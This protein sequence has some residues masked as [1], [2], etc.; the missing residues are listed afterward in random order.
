MEETA[1]VVAVT[2][3]A[4][5]VAPSF[6][7]WEDHDNNNNNNSNSNSNS[8]NNNNNSS[9]SSHNND[10]GF[11]TWDD[12]TTTPAAVVVANHDLEDN[13]N[14]DKQS[15]AGKT[16]PILP[17]DEDEEDDENDDEDIGFST[18]EHENHHNNHNNRNDN[19]NNDDEPFFP[20]VT[21][22]EESTSHHDFLFGNN[23]NNNN[24]SAHWM[25]PEGEDFL[26]PSSSSQGGAKPQQQ[27]QQALAATSFHSNGDNE[28]DEDLFAAASSP[29][30]GTK[31]KTRP[32]LQ[33]TKNH[34]DEAEAPIM[35]EFVFPNDDDND[36]QDDDE[37]VMVLDSEQAQRP[38]A[39]LQLQQQQQFSSDPVEDDEDDEDHAVPTQEEMEAGDG[40]AAFVDDENDNDDK[41]QEEEE[42]APPSQQPPANDEDDSLDS[43]SERGGEPPQPVHNSSSSSSKSRTD[44]KTT[45]KK[46][47]TSVDQS[48]AKAAA[49]TANTNDHSSSRRGKSR[50]SSRDDDDDDDEKQARSSGKTRSSS[51]SS[52]T[53]KSSRHGYSRDS[54]RKLA[55]KAASLSSSSS[56]LIKSKDGDEHPNN[57]NNNNDNNN[58]D[59]ENHASSSRKNTKKKKSS[60]S[61]SLSSLGAA[62]AEG[63]RGTASAETDHPTEAAEAASLPSS[64][65]ANNKKKRSDTKKSAAATK[66]RDRKS[67]TQTNSPNNHN[68]KKKKKSSSFSSSSSGGGGGGGEEPE[69]T[70]GEAG[71]SSSKS[72]S[73]KKSS[74]SSSS[75]SKRRKNKQVVKSEALLGLVAHVHDM[76]QEV[77]DMAA[78]AESGKDKK[79]KGSNKDNNNEET[80][81]DDCQNLMNGFESLVGI[82]LQLSDEVE[83][84]STCFARAKDQ[85]ASQ[86]LNSLL[87][88]AP[89]LD[90]NFVQL[91]P[92]LKHYLS[93]HNNPKQL[94][95]EE[96]GDLFYG[97]HLVLELLCELAQRVGE[98]QEW[99]PRACTAWMT[100][101]ELLARDT[102]EV[103]SVYNDVDT[104]SYQPSNFLQQAWLATGHIKEF[105]SLS[106]QS[107]DLTVFRQIAYE[108]I[109]SCDQWCT[110]V[111]T[112]MDIC[113]IDE[114]MLEEGHFR[115]QVADAAAAAAAF[116]AAAQD[117]PGLAPAPEGALQVLEKIMHG[118]PP[119]PRRHT[120][121]CI[122]RRLLPGH[123]ITD[124]TLS[125]DSLVGLKNDKKPV[126]V[127]ST[128]IAISSIPERSSSSMM[129]NNNKKNAKP[130]PEAD[131]NL[132]VAG[133]GKSTLAAMVATHPDVRRQFSDGI[134]W[135]YLGNRELNYARYVQCLKDVLT[136]L[137]LPDVENEPLFPELLPTPGEPISRSRRREEGFMMF[138]RE[139]MANFLQDLNV[140]LILDDVWLDA[141]LDWFDFGAPEEDNN[142]EPVEG[143]CFVL[144]T[145]RR[146]DLLPPHDT[147]EVDVLEENEA[148]QLLIQ[149][150]GENLASTLMESPS[151]TQAV[152]RECANHPL[153]V[154]SVG[155][156]L[157]LKHAT[158]ARNKEESGADGSEGDA[159]ANDVVSSMEKIL[160]SGTSALGD[161]GDDMMYEILNMSLS[162]AI[163]GEPTTII[164]FCFAA[165]V[166]VFCDKEYIS[167][168]ALADASPIV[169]LVT[170]EVLFEGLL[171]LEE[172]NLRREGS[173]FHDKKRDAAVLIPEA[174]TSLGVLKVIETASQPENEE[175]S[176]GG[177]VEKYLQVTHIVQQEYGEYLLEEDLSLKDFTVRAERRWNRTYCETF[178]TNDV[179]WDD[180][181]PDAGLDYALEMMPVHMIRG[182]MYNDAVKL[183]SNDK[184]VRGRL[185]ALGR[186]NGAR[187]HIH[188]CE[189]LFDVL[190]KQRS[191]S[192]G[193]NRKKQ[194]DPRSV[195]KQAFK[196]L[197]EHLAMDEEDY[198]KEEGSPEAVEVGRCEFEIGFSLAKKRCW[199]AAIA[200]W[201]RS[202]EL[203]VSSLGMVEVV[204]GVLFN[205]G[206]VYA[207]RTDGFDQAL[208]ALKQCLRIRGAIH[209]ED[210]IL[211]A[212]T[213]QKIGD[214][215][216]AMS[217]YSEAMESYNWALDVMHVE[218]NH[219][220]I[221][222]GDILENMGRIHFSKGEIEDKA[223]Q[224][225]EDALRSK[226]ADL[227]KE[228]AEL[229]SI[230]ENIGHCLADD[231]RTVEDAIV[232]Y[233]ESIRLRQLDPHG[234]HE[235]D[236]DV[237]TT[238]GILY[239]LQYHLQQ[240]QQHKKKDKKK[241]KEKGQ[242]QDQQEKDLQQ[243]GIECYE[244]ALSI[245]VTKV[246][247]RKEKVASLLHSI[248]LVYWDSGEPKKA[249][250]LFEE[251]LQAR[252]KV[253]GYVHLDVA[254][255]LFDTARLH[256]S[257]QR[258]DKAL[259]CLEEALKIRQLR[260]PES[261]PV[262]AT[263]E[264]IGSVARSIGKAK[265][266]EMAL[267]EALRIRK[268]IHGNDH[269]AVA[270]VLQELGDMFDGLGDYE[271]ASKCYR[272]AL[273]IRH[274][275]LGAEDLAVAETF[276]SMGHLLMHQ[277]ALDKALE[278]L[279]ESYSIRKFK[280]GEDAKECG[281]CLNAM[282]SIQ[283]KRHEMD[284]ALQILTE[285]LRIRKIQGDKT[286]VSDTLEHIGNVH[287]EK[288]EYDLAK[289]RY[290]EC[291]KVRKQALG[292][293][294]D[295]DGVA[296]A[297]LAIGHVYSDRDKLPKAMESYQQALAIRSRLHGDG[298]ES[299]ALVLQAM[300]T[301]E[302]K[303]K[304]LDRA[305]KLLKEFMSIREANEKDPDGD[306]VNALFTIGN[307]HKL[308]GNES[309]ALSSW[310]NAYNLFRE[311][312]LAESN[313]QVAAAME[314]Q[315]RGVAGS[316]FTEAP[317]SARTLQQ[318]QQRRL[319]SSLRLDEDQVEEQQQ[320]KKG[321]FGR[322]KKSSSNA[323]GSGGA[324]SSSPAAAPFK[325]GNSTRG[326]RL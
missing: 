160:R 82:L 113:G 168:F 188:D 193:S 251:S 109:V 56:S 282:G 324:K 163:N 33:A 22:E 157:H 121:S 145:T 69:E 52:S 244:K 61:S 199:E 167:D 270:K 172:D 272:E 31:K 246:P 2:S 289:D 65:S 72:S 137:D 179:E 124:P 108:V 265:K 180:E 253:C 237:F 169:P 210:H 16:V 26:G 176:G 284:S 182:G 51:S 150:S 116:V 93:H 181:S 126:A 276:F 34:H 88:F 10:S 83:L 28:D 222:I 306:Y 247:H 197:G 40:T 66:R 303:A 287:R 305:M 278:C 235:R 97:M 118:G 54:M 89:L 29:T 271:E 77:E 85:A 326:Q 279:D 234:G 36:N 41:D 90:Q 218:P 96:L 55:A 202:Q 232:H 164:K 9:K 174:L 141:D 230:Y 238:Q 100:L 129:S 308:Q 32:K 227:G 316:S 219:H 245:L 295:D 206:V 256:Q 156:W 171:T 43:E 175:D 23:N 79:S 105:K 136:Q 47:V 86:A 49:A 281:D 211:Y 140:L 143:G 215:F 138:V 178:L 304:R 208:S 200:H 239:N 76:L 131:S 17:D 153:A 149:E 307:I 268:A 68:N 321:M 283:I 220:R 243:Q 67:S 196:V 224:C 320:R 177:L 310:T 159:D 223:L 262:A 267:M 311:L 186:E 201:E 59:D 53:P 216:W 214:I 12:T 14:E 95:D 20:T 292:G 242:Q 318:P 194:L 71:A 185:F 190:Q 192:S 319:S 144:L 170:A 198:I 130:E 166:R 291:L 115:P 233:K 112:L 21:D 297:Y 263:H 274:D 44:K 158:A 184:F 19:P 99:N 314:R 259:K 125:K 266:A 293:A 18:T 236:A 132:G 261:I 142:G 258:Y 104:P 285:A 250:K 162:P 133:V 15:D 119:I 301:V 110:N 269:V 155:R 127:T 35:A 27:R 254:A 213:I 8:N 106:K 286:K 315:L 240:Q 273:K 229:A 102:L 221:D 134:A 3:P 120:L 4:T 231:S 187:R 139:S 207:Q 152:V 151:K 25:E 322:L 191:S 280:L 288:Q 296:D 101:L 204:A 298:D 5:A 111:E 189:I 80:P 183:L 98:R 63:E 107:N 122:M 212:Q 148:I 114:T 241:N 62:T 248:A 290:E 323:K 37:D 103:T 91:S 30:R 228:S 128:M 38:P 205:V 13:D 78:A 87:D 94:L 249:L 302:F 312:G 1:A 123:K 161:E 154:K 57:N 117:E 252:R 195:L 146:R 48:F 92:A 6:S 173:L 73:K 264:K 39:A 81:E 209:G 275:K 309:A 46:K 11:M 70:S 165:F 64:S 317:P 60:S 313:P 42:N 7:S 257:R 135:I 226:V 300:G 217:D 58:D 74:S 75:S 147:V 255:T 45:K 294:L 225:F 50:S 277:G 203:F 299:V 84:M 325:R 260:L 24:N